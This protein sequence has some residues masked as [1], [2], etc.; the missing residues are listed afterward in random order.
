MG[1]SSFCILSAHLLDTPV[2]LAHGAL[3]HQSSLSYLRQNFWHPIY[4]FSALPHRQFISQT[5]LLR[6]SHVT[7]MPKGFSQRFLN[8]GKTKTN[9]YKQYIDTDNK[10]LS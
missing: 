9:F 6:L 2:K 10:V 5:Q 4:I 7:D 8:V 1:M 3:E